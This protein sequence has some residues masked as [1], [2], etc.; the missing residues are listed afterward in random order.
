LAKPITSYDER[1][2]LVDDER[3]VDIVYLDFSKVYGAVFHR[4]LIEKLMKYGTD[5]Q[6]IRRIENWLNGQAQR[7]LISGAKSSGSQ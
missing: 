4:I 2:A 5:K 3:A 1:I 6:M 7:V